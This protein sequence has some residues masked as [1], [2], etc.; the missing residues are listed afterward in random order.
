VKQTEEGWRWKFD[1]SMF[2][3]LERLFGYKF[4]F[5][6]PALFI[7]GADSLLMSLISWIILKRHIPTLWIL[8]K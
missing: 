3:S 1:D 2:N 8:T 6:C 4:S 7:H 5:G